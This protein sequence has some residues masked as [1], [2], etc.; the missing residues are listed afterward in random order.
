MQDS[1]DYARQAVARWRGYADKRMTVRTLKEAEQKSLNSKEEFA[2]LLV[3][4]ADWWLDRDHPLAFVY[5][6]RTWCNGFYLEFMAGHPLTE[7]SIKG[8]LR[9]SIQ[10]L[11]NMAE[12]THGEWIWWETTEH[13]LDFYK[14]CI[15]GMIAKANVLSSTLPP[16]EDVFLVRVAELRG[17][18]KQS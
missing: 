6:R 1:A 16:V 14:G 7:G 13:S 10:C 9:A 18:L 17:L 4:K 2:A 8:I 11:V 3:L 12:T 5:V 15:E